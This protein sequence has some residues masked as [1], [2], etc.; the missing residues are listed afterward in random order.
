MM[1][2][3]VEHSL[4]ELTDVMLLKREARGRLDL[5]HDQVKGLSR[6]IGVAGAHDL[7]PLSWIHEMQTDLVKMEKESRAEIALTPTSLREPST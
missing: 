4:R 2:G 5:W 3:E 6:H 7:N 1:F